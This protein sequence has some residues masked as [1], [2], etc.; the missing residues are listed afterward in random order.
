[1]FKWSTDDFSPSQRLDAYARMLDNRILSITTSSPVRFNFKAEMTA[2]QLGPLTVSRLGGSAHD[3]Y[4]TRKDIARAQEFTY[5]LTVGVGCNWRHCKKDHQALLRPGDVLLADTRDE[6]SVHWPP[7]CLALNVRLPIEWL[8]AWIADPRQLVGRRISGDGGW[9]KMLSNYISLVTPELAT[10]PPLPAQVM[11]DQVGAL[12]AL[13]AQEMQ[14]YSS[15]SQA[16]NV[17]QRDRIQA[18]I[19]Q[20]CSELQLTAAHVAASLNLSSRTLH[21]TLAAGGE[22]FGKQLIDARLD[23]AL[24]MLRSNR[25]IE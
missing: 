16:S 22:T 12:L 5:L 24:R 9:G 21:R 6:L 1:M 23:R 4:R 18:C 15:N 10:A 25:L 3:A 19:E 7:D 14:G 8:Q 17:Q 11:A 2:A 13:A 20:R